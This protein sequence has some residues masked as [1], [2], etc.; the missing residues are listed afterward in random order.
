MFVSIV[1]CVGK[2]FIGEWC[3]VA[4][5]AGEAAGT[6]PSP[7][8]RGSGARGAYGA[9]EVACGA[10]AAYDAGTGVRGPPAVPRRLAACASAGTAVKHSYAPAARAACGTAPAYDASARVGGAAG[11]AGLSRRTPPYTRSCP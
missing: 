1:S 4:L 9:R 2:M 8:P 3:D 10:R 6:P 11:K 5:H 7:R